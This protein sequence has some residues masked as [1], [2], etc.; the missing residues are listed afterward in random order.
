MAKSDYNDDVGSDLSEA[1][2][3]PEA[4]E[5]R[6]QLIISS[7]GAAHLARGKKAQR[8]SEE[9]FE[10]GHFNDPKLSFIMDEEMRKEKKYSKN[11]MFSKS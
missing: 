4:V 9:S 3:E 11:V 10:Q 2:S 7:V 5:L 1:G 8:F 6:N